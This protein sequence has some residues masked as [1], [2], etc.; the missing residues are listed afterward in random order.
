MSHMLKT[1]YVLCI[2]ETAEQMSDQ[3]QLSPHTSKAFKILEFRIWNFVLAFSI[4]CNSR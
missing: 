4:V 2:Y 1:E 3:F